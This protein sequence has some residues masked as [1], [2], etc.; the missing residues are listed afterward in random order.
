[1]VHNEAVF[2]GEIFAYD[3]SVKNHIARCDVQKEDGTWEYIN[4]LHLYSLTPSVC[5]R[6]TALKFGDGLVTI[7]VSPGFVCLVDLWGA[8]L[9]S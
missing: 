2:E 6:Y 4:L 9:R 5:R 8:A 7:V 3:T 1:V